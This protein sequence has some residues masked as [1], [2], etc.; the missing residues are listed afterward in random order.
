MAQFNRRDFLKALGVTGVAASLPVAGAYAGSHG[1]TRARVVVVGGGS[2]GATAARYL[3]KADPSI[4]V[5]LIEANPTY[6]TCYFSNLVIGGMLPID[7]IKHGYDGLRRYGVNVVHDTVVGI[8]PV[9]RKVTAS[10][11]Q[12]FEY[13]RL[14]LSPGIELR[15]NA[16]EGYDETASQTMPHAW[17]AGDQTLLLR[18]QLEAMPDGGVVV[19]AAPPNPFRC[20]PGPYERASLIANYL[21]THKPRAKLIVVD[22][23]DAF[24]KQGLFEQ[25]W[26]MY[27]PGTLEWVRA[28]D[29]NGGIRRVD[30]RAMTL[31]GEFHQFKADVANVIPPQKAGR[32]AGDAGLVDDSGWCPVNRHTFESTIAENVHVIGDAASAAAMPKSGYAASSQ[33]KVAALAIASIV[34]GQEPPAPSYVN[35]CYSFGNPEHAFSVTGVYRLGDGAIEQVAGGVSPIDAPQEFR[36]REVDYAYSWYSNLTHEMFG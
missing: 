3:K 24:S 6:H 31:H 9:A 30:T 26:N 16:I 11:G 5:T 15:W 12:T 13:D 36:R 23:K 28:A 7:R 25:A 17:K 35:T 33:G 8:D 32:I 29:T 14:V 18:R 1:G 34:N 2:G 27:Y 22:A 10:S 4:D 21:R 19:M 20:P